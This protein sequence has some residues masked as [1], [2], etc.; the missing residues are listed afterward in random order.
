MAPR[1]SK[2]TH[3]MPANQ[4]V[5][6]LMRIFQENKVPLSLE[7]LREDPHSYS[8]FLVEVLSRLGILSLPGHS[9]IR[10]VLIRYYIDQFLT[11]YAQEMGPCQEH[12][13]TT[14]GMAQFL[15]KIYLTVTIGIEKL[16]D[17]VDLEFTSHFETGRSAMTGFNIDYFFSN[18]KK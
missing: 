3:R 13:Y 10:T 18:I 15:I 14:L 12:Y 4:A 11:A 1:R 8:H 9:N 7:R 16:T 5:V 2:K 17:A 6:D